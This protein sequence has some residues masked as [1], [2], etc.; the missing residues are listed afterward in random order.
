MRRKL[1]LYFSVYGTTKA[2]AEAIAKH[3]KADLF[4]IEP[5]N[6][7]DSNRNHYD[8]LARRAKREYENNIR[9]GI[10]NHIPVSDYD[11]IFIGYPIWWYSLPMILYTLFESYDSSF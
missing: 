4:A 5:V 1:V 3:T 2:V 8:M 9:P 10:K 6:S 11:D 7:Y